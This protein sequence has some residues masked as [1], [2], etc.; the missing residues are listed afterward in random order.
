[1]RLVCSIVRDRSWASPLSFA[2]PRLQ[3]RSI[4]SRLPAQLIACPSVTPAQRRSVR[5]ARGRADAARLRGPSLVMGEAPDG[6]AENM[7]AIRGDRR[8]AF[9]LCR[10]SRRRPAGRRLASRPVRRRDR[11][12]LLYGRGAVD[13]KSAI[14]A[15]VAAAVARRASTG[16]DLPDHHRRRGRPCDLR[17]AADHRLAERAADPARHDPDRRADL[18][19]PARRHRQD[20]PA[21][22]GQHVDRGARR[23][24]PRRL[25][26]TAPTTRSRRWRGSSRRS[27]RSTSTTATTP[28]SRRTSS[29]PRSSTPTNASNVI[30]GA[31]TA[32]LNIRFNNLQRGADLVRMVEEIAEREAPGAKV[33]ARISG[34]AFLTPP[35]PLYDVIVEAIEEETGIATGALDQRRHVRRPL[36]DPAL[37]GRRFRPSQRDDAQARRSAAVEDIRR[38]VEDLRADPAEG[39]G[40]SDGPLRGAAA[41]R[42]P[43]EEFVLEHRRARR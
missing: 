13:M 14:A 19:R 33:R 11:G 9:R 42:G 38:A 34:E 27:T 4:P 43:G 40:L 6:P 35:G 29:S 26:R 7:F 22:L 3:C 8:A 18:G 20:R 25:S 10:P 1:M 5:R 23:A 30:P 15:F 28:S 24:G 16:H 39:A 12:G 37:P 21:R 32:Q 36:P 41:A 2:R 31:A 17:H